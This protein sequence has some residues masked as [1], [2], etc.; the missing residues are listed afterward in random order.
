M[1]NKFLIL[2]LTLLFAFSGTK[3]V[4]AQLQSGDILISTSPENPKQNEAVT[5]ALSSYT[6]DLNK[7][8]VSWLVNGKEVL[9][10]IGKKVF[11]FTAGGTDSQTNVQAKI[12]TTDG[13]TVLKN[14]IVKPADINMLWEASD[15]Y[16]PPFYRGKSFVASEGSFKI[17]AIPNLSSAKGKL[18]INSLSYKWRKDDK[19][20]QSQSGFGKN[21]LVIKTSY[22]DQ[23]THVLVNVS[24]LE[25]L[26]SGSGE[27]ILNAI[28]PKILFYENDP[29]LGIQ[30]QKGIETNYDL[31]KENVSFFTA[32]YFFSPKNINANDL[33]FTW[34]INGEDIT[35]PSPKNILSIKPNAGEK[36]TANIKL[37]IDNTNTLFQN[38]EKTLNVNF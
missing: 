33:S 3:L 32:P 23:D 26:T 8:N 2:F 21:S 31:T 5:V 35:T 12:N 9:S 7:A 38:L 16:S 37:K 25:S 19:A 22:L 24:D 18:P 11:S 15:S 27:I 36:G 14:I 6:T 20:Q 1:R 28:R 10:G 34:N 30:F 13:S 4:F 17:V 29:E